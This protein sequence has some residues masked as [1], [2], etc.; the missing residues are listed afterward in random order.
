M[1]AVLKNDRDANIEHSAAGYARAENFKPEELA[2]LQV[3]PRRVD[4]RT[5][6]TQERRQSC[7]ADPGYK[8]NNQALLEGH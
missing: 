2:R 7:E 3:G 5:T 8:K 1:R 6:Q 4:K